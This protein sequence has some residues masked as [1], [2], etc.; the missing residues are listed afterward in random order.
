MG[1]AALSLGRASLIASKWTGAPVVISFSRHR[2]Q[3]GPA[4]AIFVSAAFSITFF[5]TLGD[6][7][8]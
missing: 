6:E 8:G 2:A 1:G 3:S 7:P 5:G 4:S